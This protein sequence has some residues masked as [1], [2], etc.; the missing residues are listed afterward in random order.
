MM[1]SVISTNPPY[2]YR[3]AVM[4]VAV[5]FSDVGVTPSVRGVVRRPREL[6][7]LNF[8]DWVLFPG[9]DFAW[10]NFSRHR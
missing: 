5:N 1:M 2:W 3:V 10:P 9:S 7:R 4:S 6:Y 8:M